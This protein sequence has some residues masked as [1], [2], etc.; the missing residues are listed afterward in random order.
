MTNDYKENSLHY[1][2]GDLQQQTGLNI[3]SFNVQQI[4]NDLHTLISSQYNILFYFTYIQASSN[5]HNDLDISILGAY[6]SDGETAFGIFVLLDADNNIIQIIDKWSDGTPIG[7]I[8]CMSVDENGNYYAVE[9]KS[10]TY[11]IVELNNIALKLD[12]QSEYSATVLKDYS[13]SGTGSVYRFSAIRRNE[14]KSKYLLLYETTSNY[15][16][17]KEFDTG[18]NTWTTYSSTSLWA[19]DKYSMY[20]FLNESFNVYWDKDNNVQFQIATYSSNQFS[21][22]TNNDTTTMQKTNIFSNVVSGYT[23]GNA[24][25]V[26]YSNTIGYLAVVLENSTQTYN[27]YQ[28][29]KVNL[30][31]NNVDKIIDTN[32]DYSDY[33]RNFVFKG[34]GV[35]FYTE[36]TSLDGTADEAQVEFAFV[37]DT[38][39]IGETLG[40]WQSSD[41]RFFIGFPNVYK[42]YSQYKVYLQ[43]QNTVFIVDFNWNKNEYNGI[44]FISY[45]SLVPRKASI[46]DTSNTEI[47][48]R[49]LYS[50][51]SYCNQYT[52]TLNIPHEL[53]N[54]I[55]FDRTN[56]Y[57][58]NNNLM[59]QNSLSTQKNKFEELNINFIQTYNIVDNQGNRNIQASADLVDYMLN[60]S[61]NGIITKAKINYVDNTNRI[62]SVSATDSNPYNANISVAIYVDKAIKNIELLSDNGLTS[63]HTIKGDTLELN[64]YYLIKQKVKIE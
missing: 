11:R 17:A 16:Y 7:D 6:V 62:I 43:G 2:V 4:D 8:Q 64:K 15:I 12:S 52:A 36:Y 23:F 31:N 33:N 37:D 51:S 24:D 39:T 59:I 32:V 44:E 35:V 28:L 47:F 13:I 3:P 58:K 38:T 50:L 27:K 48:N 45:G 42:N 1:L 54:E 60:E 53:L 20:T 5:K 41:F 55:T 26:F 22:L 57:S 14:N 19:N 30:M 61:T 49:D 40:T 46:I 18:N 9:R 25:F 63:Y 34:G 29:F 56:L 21:I 10:T